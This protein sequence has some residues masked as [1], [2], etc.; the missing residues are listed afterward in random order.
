MSNIKQL[1]SEITEVLEDC[2]LEWK[3]EFLNYKDYSPNFGLEDAIPERDFYILLGKILVHQEMQFEQFLLQQ[4]ELEK[5]GYGKGW[6]CRYSTKDRGLRI[7]E[8]TRENAKPTIIE[9]IRYFLL[10]H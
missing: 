2:G 6:V 8:T 5:Q 9:A 10:N 7:H 4:L 3:E 1:I